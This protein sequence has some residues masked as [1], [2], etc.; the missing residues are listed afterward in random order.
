MPLANARPCPGK[1]PRSHSCPNFI[2]GSIRYCPQCEVYANADKSERDQKRDEAPDRKF[3]H[4]S[5][6]RKERSLY[7]G[8]NPLCERCLQ[9]NIE[10]PAVLVHH[11]D[12]NELNR[13][14]ENKEALCNNCH[15]AIHGPSRW[16][17]K[18]HLGMPI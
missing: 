3:L 12:G 8:A 11:R 9:K 18:P 15:E 7:L 6:W 17:H 5:L 16:Q 4:S 10:R 2:R 1:G 14:Q 13:V